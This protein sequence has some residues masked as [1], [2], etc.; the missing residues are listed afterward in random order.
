MRRSN[1]CLVMAGVL[2]AGLVCCEDTGEGTS[3]PPT[4]EGA[5]AQLVE[6]SRSDAAGKRIFALLDMKSRWSVMSIYKDQ[7]EACRL[8][9]S[10]YPAARRPRE[11][12]RCEGAAAAKDAAAFFGSLA[13]SQGLL[14]GLDRIGAVGARQRSSEGITFESGGQRI[15]L[16]RDRGGWAFCGL[17]E[18]LEKVKLKTSRDLRTI[19]ENAEVYRRR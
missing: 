18:E 10:A 2:G 3:R 17:R 1:V 13:R 9:H 11:L 8:V 19:R 7:R 6:A 4:A 14:H 5:F 12:R 15:L 16:C